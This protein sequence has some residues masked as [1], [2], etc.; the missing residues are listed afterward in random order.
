MEVHHHAHHEG[1]KSWRTYFWEFLMLFLAVFCG[2][3]AEYQLE[4]VIEHNREKQF[5]RTY[6]EDLKADT[7]A[8]SKNIKYRREKLV[9][10]D[11]LMFLLGNQK[12]KGYE[13]DL[14]YL[15]RILVRTNR[16]QSNDRTIIQLK[17]SGSLRLIRNEAAADSMVS[18]Q[19]LVEILMVNQEDERDERNKAY[20]IASRMF[21][22]FVFD[23]ML[24]MSGVNRPEGNPPLRTY[25]PNVQ[26]DL[27]AYVHTI[28]GSTL[29]IESRLELL[30]GKAKDLMSFLTKEYDIE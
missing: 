11:S 7:A 26:M 15:G 14:Y 16:F 22:P 25:D 30:H 6:I 21:N 9:Q 5:I 17:N 23:K 29:L 20:E 27:A 18:Y 10:L 3:L 24:T 13:S 2:F 4:H 28:K 1:K 12:I 19:K 8:I